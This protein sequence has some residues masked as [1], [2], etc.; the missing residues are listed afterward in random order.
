MSQDLWTAVDAYI[1]DLFVP[2]DPALDA[3]LQASQSA[4]LPAIQVSPPQGKLLYLLARLISARRIL[5][6]GTLGGYSTIWLGRGLTAGGRLI[7][8][9]SEPRH[10]EVARQNIAR[11]GLASRVE[12]RLGMA[13]DTLPQ[14]AAEG[15]GPFDLI[16]I[17]ADKASYP[18]YLEWALR[19]S[20][21]G[22]LLLADNVVRDG[23]IIDAECTNANLQATRRFNALL[24]AD[25]RVSAT[26][27]QV[28]GVK[29]YDGL[30]LAVV[31]D[32]A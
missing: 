2:A 19:L 17:D 8:L 7:S 11:A 23:T 15:A 5:E 31:V 30:A 32:S 26:V 18:A 22:T 13:L 27:L 1:A 29:G 9:E 24:A 6:I 4:G 16:F 12:V 10:A 14:I 3:A 28:V 25:K 21:P 20:R